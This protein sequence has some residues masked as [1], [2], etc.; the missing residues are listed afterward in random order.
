M[1]MAKQ[2]LRQRALRTEFHSRFVAREEYLCRPLTDDEVRKEVNHILM[3][4]PCSNVWEA[5]DTKE[6]EKLKR[7]LMALTNG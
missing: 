3:F 7:Q 4:L 6:R 1:A 5:A 2:S